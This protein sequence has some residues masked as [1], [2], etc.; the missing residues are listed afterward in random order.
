MERDVSMGTLLSD[1]SGKYNAIKVT[2]VSSVA[3][4]PKENVIKLCAYDA[5]DTFYDIVACEKK[6]MKAFPPSSFR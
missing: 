5:N 2:S 4:R 6:Y 1:I 3:K